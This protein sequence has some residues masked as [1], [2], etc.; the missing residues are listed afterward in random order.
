MTLNITTW[1]SNSPSSSRLP[2]NTYEHLLQALAQTGFE[3]SAEHHAAATPPRSSKLSVIA[4][5]SSDKVYDRADSK[6]QIIF[7]KGKQ[8]DPFGKEKPLAVQV[9][10][11]LRKYIEPRSDVLD[12]SLAR[13][14]RP[15]TREPPASEESD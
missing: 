1:P 14:E 12:F 8:V 15:P 10:W 3:R 5:G 2:R 13:S 6:N 7:V 4:F 9:G 11:C